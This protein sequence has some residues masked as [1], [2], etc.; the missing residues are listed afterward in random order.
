M[1]IYTYVTLYAE[2]ASLRDQTIKLYDFWE[3]TGS[4]S[5]YP[6]SGWY[7]ADY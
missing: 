3:T 1:W 5:P 2:S 6:P 7:L 4:D